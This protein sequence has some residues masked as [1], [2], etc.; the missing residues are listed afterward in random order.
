MGDLTVHML[1]LD[2]DIVSF[3]PLFLSVV[4]QISW[5]ISMQQL[6]EPVSEVSTTDRDL[7][8]EVR[9]GV[10]FVNGYSV[11]DTFAGIE[12]STSRTASREK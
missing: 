10:T 4:G 8:D 11:S 6:D 7:C 12:H 5:I 3:I 9:N 1:N 2:S